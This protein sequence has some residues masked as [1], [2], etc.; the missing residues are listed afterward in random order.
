VD[1]GGVGRYVAAGVYQQVAGAP[2]LDASCL[3]A[4]HADGHDVVATQV[5]AGGLEVDRREHGLAPGH[6]M[7]R[8]GVRACVA[9]RSA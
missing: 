6:V 7:L 8:A 9:Q 4:D 1:A 5:Q 2:G 3:D